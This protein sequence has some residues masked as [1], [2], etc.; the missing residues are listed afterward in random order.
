LP[1]VEHDVPDGQV[2][3]MVRPEAVTLASHTTPESGPLV[4]TVIAVTFLGATSRV[5]VD[6]GDVTVLAQ[7]PTSDAT[8]LP[9]GSRVAL[10]IRPDP[11]LVS[12]D[13]ESSAAAGEEA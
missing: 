4:G 6:L 1:L 8:K 5:T 2:V 7:L 13:I 3:A 9:A 11:V 10:T 12:A